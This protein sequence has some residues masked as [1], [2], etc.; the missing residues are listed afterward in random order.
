M[1]NGDKFIAKMIVKGLYVHKT[2]EQSQEKQKSVKYIKK[3]VAKLN[4]N[5][6]EDS[7]QKW[8]K[9]IHNPTGLAHCFTCLKLNGCWFIDSKRPEC[10]QHPN[11]HCF[12]ENLSYEEVLNR[13]KSISEYSKFDPYLFNT[14]NKYS[15][16]K[17]K[18][19]L[20][21][22]YTVN[23]AK[24]L[25]TEIERQGLD[26]YIKGNYILGK[27]DHNGQR[28]SIRVT[29]PRKN[30]GN[31]ISF[32]TGWILYPNGQIKLTTPFGGK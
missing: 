31:D 8:I 25:Q 13:A 23:D 16:G 15:H 6:K 2:Y 3:W 7:L 24:W 32:V 4:K 27:L 11:C 28:I 18:L 20:E 30:N 12:L 9:W 14:G 5:I 1:R 22:G 17:E 26:N 10:P 29:I 19:F 21:W